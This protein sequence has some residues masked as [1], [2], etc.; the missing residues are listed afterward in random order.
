[1]GLRVAL[2]DVSFASGANLA[3]LARSNFHILKLD[4]SLTSQI[5]PDCP[6]PEWLNGVSALRQTS[7]LE[8][9]AE[10]VETE[11]QFQTLRSVNIQAGQGFYFSP[12]IR[13][14]AFIAYQRSRSGQTG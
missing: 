5:T 13:A 10:G 8:V 2:D 9:I 1:M 7:K 6:I 12:P 4:R 14:E 11:Q 3:V